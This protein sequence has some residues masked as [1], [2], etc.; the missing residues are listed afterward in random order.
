MKPIEQQNRYG[1]PAEVAIAFLTEPRARM[2]N[3]F[4]KTCQRAREKVYV[5]SS[6]IH[7]IVGQD[8]EGKIARAWGHTEIQPRSAEEKMKRRF[9]SASISQLSKWLRRAI[10]KR[11]AVQRAYLAIEGDSPRAQ[12]AREVLAAVAQHLDTIRDVCED[13][14]KMRKTKCDAAAQRP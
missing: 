1:M 3:S 5:S 9:G 11:P 2:S 8:S 6:P 14:I 7:R 10:A 4:R 12:A 13:E